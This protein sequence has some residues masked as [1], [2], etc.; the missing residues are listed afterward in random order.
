MKIGVEE[1][2]EKGAGGSAK[3]AVK[4]SSDVEVIKSAPEGEALM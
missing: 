1:D 4:E 3:G 2:V